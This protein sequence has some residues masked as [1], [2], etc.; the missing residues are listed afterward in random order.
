MKNVN[1]I[2]ACIMF[3]ACQVEDDVSFRSIDP[4]CIE[5]DSAPDD[6]WVCSEPLTIDCNDGSVPEQIYVR[7]DDGQCDDV[8]LQEIPGPFPPG[9]YDVVVIDGNTDESVCTTHLTVTDAVAPVITAK[10]VELWPPNHKLHDFTLADLVTV[11]DCDG[12]WSAA[13]DYVTSDEPDD[14]NGDGHT[15]G[16]VVVTA[17][18]ALQLRSERQGG[19]DG[20]VYT[21]GLTVTDGSGNAT[22]STAT[23][24][25]PHDRGHG[26]GDDGEAYRLRLTSR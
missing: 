13:I 25:V 6:A 5:D 26:A 21:I 23:V 14:D 7:L 2:A 8:A 10:A 3:A 24:T 22:S 15:E 11:D 12:N 18:D 16:D 4:V 20:R 17:S 1:V 9:E 19:G